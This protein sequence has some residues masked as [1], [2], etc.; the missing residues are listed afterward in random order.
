MDVRA[1]ANHTDESLKQDKADHT[2]E[3]AA[4]FP[5]QNLKRSCGMLT[6]STLSWQNSSHDR[7][8]AKGNLNAH[9]C[10]FK[11]SS[12]QSGHRAYAIAA[13]RQAFNPYCE[14][15]R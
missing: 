2:T 7:V 1:N 15:F 11:V 4:A 5:C 12:K 3:C 13:A 8:Q 9:Q 10:R 6:C 14:A